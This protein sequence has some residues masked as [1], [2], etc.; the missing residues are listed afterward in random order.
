MPTKIEAKL[1]SLSCLHGVAEDLGRLVDGRFLADEVE[2]VAELQAHVRHGGQNH[3][4]AADAADGHAEA[5]GDLRRGDGL[6]DHVLVGDD[7]A[8]GGDGARIGP[9]ILVHLAAHAELGAVE[10]LR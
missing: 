10:L 1:V 3:V 5:L 7:H 8:L 2:H 9:Q 6:A 4:L